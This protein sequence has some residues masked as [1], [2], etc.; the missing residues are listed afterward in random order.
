MEFP[1]VKEFLV[2]YSQ[3]AAKEKVDLLGFYLPPYNYAIGQMLEQAITA[4]KSL[5]NKVLADYLRRKELQTIVGPVR[6]GKDGEWA[7]PRIVMIQFRG[8]SGRNIEQ[9]RQ[10]GKQVILEPEKLQTG[11]LVAPFEQARR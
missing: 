10:P 4:S 1:G 7:T 9:F 3:R 6:F 11:K 2:R 8:V 5:D